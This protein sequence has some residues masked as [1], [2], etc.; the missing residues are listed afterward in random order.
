M[1]KTTNKFSPEVRER[2]VRLVLDNEGQHGSRWQPVYCFYSKNSERKRWQSPSATAPSRNYEYGCLIADATEI[3]KKASIKK[4][5][6]VEDV[7][8]PWHIF[9]APLSFKTS[10]FFAEWADATVGTVGFLMTEG[11]MAVLNR[12]G[13]A[14]GYFG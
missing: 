1:S 10:Y 12:P 14:L 7:S 3:K 2:A 9:F 6:D 13:F 11:V 8:V 4:I 5:Q